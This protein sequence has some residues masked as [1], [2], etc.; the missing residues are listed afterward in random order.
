MPFAAPNGG[1]RQMI[2][3]GSGLRVGALP[4]TKWLPHE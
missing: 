1:R 3:Q 4:S 2:W